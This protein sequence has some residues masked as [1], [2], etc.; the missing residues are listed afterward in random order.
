METYLILST[1]YCIQYTGMQ[2]HTTEGVN[3]HYL[4]IAKTVTYYKNI[5][6]STK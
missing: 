2:I 5:E 6:K 1:H 3:Q 4:T